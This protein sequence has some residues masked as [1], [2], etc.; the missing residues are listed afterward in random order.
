MRRV[1]LVHDVMVVRN[2]LRAETVVL[3][4]VPVRRL[5][6]LQRSARRRG[7][8][9]GRK[10]ARMLV[11]RRL[12]H[13]AVVPCAVLSFPLALLAL[14]LSSTRFP[15]PHAFASV[16]RRLSAPPL[17][18]PVHL[19]P[20]PASR[21]TAPEPVL[22]WPTHRSAIA[23]H[24]RSRRM[25][26]PRSDRPGRRRGRRAAHR[27]RAMAQVPASARANTGSDAHA[28]ARPGTRMPWATDRDRAALVQILLQ[29]CLRV[30][31]EGRRR[32]MARVVWAAIPAR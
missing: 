3:Q 25:L 13:R 8:G 18:P 32:C 4:R 7:R 12:L 23:V 2:A 11:R 14:A 9:R 22:T 28:D 15:F 5:G 19:L 20:A 27:P 16:I 17:L 24:R 1:M 29:L 26:V 31:V 30:R 21:R 6:L 10:R